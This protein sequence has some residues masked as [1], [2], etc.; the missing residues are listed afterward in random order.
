MNVAQRDTAT[1]TPTHDIT[2]AI[3]TLTGASLFHGTDAPGQHHPSPVAMSKPKLKLTNLVSAADHEVLRESYTFLPP[4]AA[5]PSSSSSSAPPQPQSTSSSSTWQERMVQTYHQGLYKEFALADLSVPGKIGLRWRTK[6]EVEVGRGETTC[7]NKKCSE[8][9]AQTPVDGL[10]SLEVPFAYVEHGVRKKELVKLRLCEQCRPLV[11]HQNTARRKA[12]K[13]DGECERGGYGDKD[14]RAN[15]GD[16]GD[17]K[18]NGNVNVDYEVGSTTSK[19][20][21]DRG[22][23]KKKRRHHKNGRCRRKRRSEDGRD[24]A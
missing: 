2:T 4:P 15:D 22:N 13:A 10:V 3:T 16:I 8:S 23:A 1:L 9:H 5:T 7:G 20:S 14:D 12:G 11:V 21:N 17:R 24:E 19:T 18:R 6:Q